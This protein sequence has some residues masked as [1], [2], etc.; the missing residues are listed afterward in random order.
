MSKVVC[1]TPRLILRLA[2]PADAAFLRSLWN[3]PRVMGF[4]GFPNG[5][6]ESEERLRANIA[7]RGDSVF[8]QLILVELRETHQPIGQCKMEQLN[9]DGISETDVKLSPEFW[10][11]R[12]GVEVKR[13]LLDYLFAHTDCRVVQA[14]PNVENPASIR[15][16]E[17]VGGERV[18]E[19]L[20]EFPEAQRDVTLPVC[21]YVYQVKRE[22]W[23]KER[24][25]TYAE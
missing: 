4:V 20:F 24:S 17:S 23:L 14:T 13:A 6:G 15:M 18:G 22:T 1:Q 7:G 25:K 2:T 16:Q 12:Y 21:D 3:D 11:R 8:R 10:S 19:G 9:Q 5:L